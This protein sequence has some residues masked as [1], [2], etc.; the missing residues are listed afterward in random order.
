[1]F[2]EMLGFS[3]QGLLILKASSWWLKKN[4]MFQKEGMKTGNTVCV[5]NKRKK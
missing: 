5:T 4:S 3:N 2:L 1:M